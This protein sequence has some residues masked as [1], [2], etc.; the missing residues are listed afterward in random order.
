MRKKKIASGFIVIHSARFTES[1]L[2]AGSV[3][4][5]GIHG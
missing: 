3:L 5:A 1:V 4:G 2:R